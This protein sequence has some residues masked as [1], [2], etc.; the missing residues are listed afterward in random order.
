MSEEAFSPPIAEKI[1]NNRPFSMIFHTKFESPISAKFAEE[2][3]LLSPDGTPASN[4]SYETLEQS[5][6]AFDEGLYDHCYPEKVY[7]L[8]LYTLSFLIRCQE[9]PKV[10]FKKSS[11]KSNKG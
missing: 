9:K 11:F 6:D 4:A 8:T 10:W 1:S 5:F 3:K 2:T 7:P